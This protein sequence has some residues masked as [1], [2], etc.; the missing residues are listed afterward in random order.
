MLNNI[1]PRI[2]PCGTP[3]RISRIQDFENGVMSNTVNIDGSHGG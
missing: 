1:G 2:D 3:D